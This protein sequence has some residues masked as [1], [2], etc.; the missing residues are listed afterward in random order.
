MRSI[1]RSFRP[2]EIFHLACPS[3]LEN[4]GAFE[5]QVCVLSIDTTREF[6]RWIREESPATRFFFAGSS[7]VY[8]D[9]PSTPQ[10]ENTQSRPMH[11]Y[12]IAKLA[13]QQMVDYF[14]REHGVFGCTGI[15]FNHES[16]LRREDFVSRR[17]TRSAARIALGSQ[18]RLELGNLDAFRDWSH[19]S[20]FVR[21][22]RLALEA[23]VPGDYVFASG[24]ARTVREFVEA[25]FSEVGLDPHRHLRVRPELFREDSSLK[26]E[27]DTSRARQLLGWQ[28]ERSFDEWVREMVRLDLNDLKGAP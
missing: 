23:A 3:K 20:D 6:L 24:H 27:G 2:D 7:E 9:P 22:F 1:L 5:H 21:G 4:S 28:A 16:H 14:R 18:E 8:G 12:A 10:S 11:P 25:A 17:I 15:L 26:R 19:A 13:G